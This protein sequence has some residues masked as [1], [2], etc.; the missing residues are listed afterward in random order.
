M[1]MMAQ[2]VERLRVETALIPRGRGMVLF[3]L[4]LSMA[5]MAILG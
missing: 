3:A 4:V 1:R 2:K 5:V